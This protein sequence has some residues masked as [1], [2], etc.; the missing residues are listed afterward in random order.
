MLASEFCEIVK[1]LFGYGVNHM[2]RH[3]G[4]SAQ[5]S[6]N[7]KSFHVARILR[8]RIEFCDRNRCFDVVVL[9]SDELIDAGA[10]N[11][12]ET[13][14]AL[15]GSCILEGRAW[16]PHGAKKTHQCVFPGAGSG[17]LRL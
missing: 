17:P 2:I 3:I 14:L 6:N 16:M 13:D 9:F 1:Y 8:T 10:G 15:A 7:A 5:G 4:R 11:R 12:D